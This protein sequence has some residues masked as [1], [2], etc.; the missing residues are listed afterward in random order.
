MKNVRNVKS[1][2]GSRT[3]ANRPYSITPEFEYYFCRDTIIGWRY[4]FVAPE[5][6]EVIVE[7][8]KYCRREKGLRVHGYVVMPTHVHSILSA[9][10]GNLSDI[11]RDFKRWSSRRLSALLEE[12]RNVWLL[13]YFSTAAD[14]AGRGN[15]YKVWQ[16]SSHPECI[17]S[18]RFFREK[19]DYIHMNPVRKG[20]VAEPEG[21]LYSSARNYMLGDESVMEIDMIE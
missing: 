9:R 20:F 13:K 4:L 8:F 3:P 14:F 1:I 5:F 19:L 12:K 6:F 16:S 21:W 18:D 11:L 17:Y 15:D 10:D 7:S 2:S